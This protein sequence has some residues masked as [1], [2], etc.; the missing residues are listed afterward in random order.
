MNRRKELKVRFFKWFI[1]GMNQKGLHAK[2]DSWWKVMFLVGTD[3]FSSMGFQPSISFAA[4][5]YLAPLATLNLIIL[6]LFGALPTYF[7]V[8]KE[9]PHGQGSFAIF[10]RLLRGWTG[11]TLVLVLLGFAFTDFVFTITMCAADATAHIVENP[12]TPSIFQNRLLTTLLLILSL[13]LIFIKGFSEA[14]KVSF[15]LVAFYLAVNTVVISVCLSKLLSSPVHFTEW[16]NHLHQEHGSYLEMFKTAALVFPQLA[17][18]MSGFETGVAVMPL[19]KSNTQGTAQT[20]KSNED[21]SSD[22]ADKLDAEKEEIEESEE[23]HEEKERACLPGRIANTRKLLLT[24]A[25]IMSVFLMLGSLTT[26]LLI[27]AEL[28]QPHGKADGR[29]LAYLAHLYLGEGF[30]TIYDIATILILWFAGA[31]G[32][33][34]LLSLVPQYL[35]RYGM[36]PDW[37]K[38]R[39]P[40]VVFFTLVSL[41]VTVAFKADVDKQAGAFATGLLVMITSAAVAVTTLV[42]KQGFW[43]RLAFSAI[44]LVFVYSCFA[45]MYDRPDGLIISLLFIATVLFTSFVSRALRSTELRIGD[46]K[47]N[48]RA[49]RFINDSCQQDLGVVRILAH[50]PGPRSYKEKEL[51]A[52]ETHSIQDPEGDF[53]FFEVQVKDVS[54][55]ID[56]HLEVKG[57]TVDGYK[58]LRAESPS[59]AN[60]IAAL[61]LHIRDVTGKVP[62]VYFEWTEG[63]PL[64]Y[65]LKYILLGEGET[66]FLTR[67]I[68]RQAEPNKDKRPKVHVG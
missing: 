11:K 61:L 15:F 19:V 18:G 5:G 34:A 51:E 67:E 24:V 21:S 44:S 59:A 38:A 37:A 48:S 26:T 39:R 17:L 7:L 41:I 3:Y 42:W 53:I 8:S 1:Q 49:L 40:L 2:P 55:F 9:S 62:H 4:A 43:K 33:A 45:V 13:G 68:L 50:R 64:F 46:V 52:R 57:R 63:N 22:S 31:S 54:E 65:V 56:E 29:A 10:E 60:A 25:L 36:A 28:F 20:S 47:L 16:F 32:M 23:D 6:T 12:L 30:G 14:I 66:A 58:V 35:P 27:P